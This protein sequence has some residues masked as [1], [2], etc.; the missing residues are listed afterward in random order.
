M[1]AVVTDIFRIARSS[2]EKADA[3]GGEEAD[4]R[5]ADLSQR[6]FVFQEAV[7]AVTGEFGQPIP[8][9]DRFHPMTEQPAQIADLF[10][11]SFALR[12]RVGTGGEQEGMTT[13]NTDVLV[14]AVS[15]RQG[16]VGVMSQKAGQG[17]TH[18]CARPVLREVMLTAAAT[19]RLVASGC[20]QSVVHDVA[21]EG[22]AQLHTGAPPTVKAK[23]NGS[24]V[25][26]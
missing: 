13:A 14:N 23:S 16:D 22:A 10:R 17:M 20:E 5:V 24:R 7:P 11:E 8:L 1:T 21:P 4:E 15:I 26:V 6:S 9:D 25:K 12:K 19:A 3:V 2:R 18:V